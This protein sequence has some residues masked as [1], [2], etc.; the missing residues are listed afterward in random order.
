MIFNKRKRR[1]II[2]HIGLPKSGSTVLQQAL[3][4]QRE[5][6]LRQHVLYP[7]NVHRHDDPKHNFALD[8][9]RKGNNLNL[10]EEKGFAASKRIVISNEALSNEFYMQGI[11]HNRRLA[12]SLWQ[13]GELEICVVLR[14]PDSWLKSYY[15]QA[16]IN[17]PV[18]NKPHYQ[19]ALS[20]EAF[21][22]LEQVEKMLDQASLLLD[23]GAHYQAPVRAFRYEDTDFSAIANYCAGYSLK[24]IDTQ[25]RRNE[26]LPDV[27]VELMRQ[28]NGSITG[29]AEKHAWSYLLQRSI[30]SEHNVLN[31]LA[32]RAMPEDIG[33]LDIS[34]LDSIRP[35]MTQ[36]LAVDGNMLY[37]LSEKLRS[38]FI[39]YRKSEFIETSRW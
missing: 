29:L 15:K 18:K 4:Q 34:K 16:V 36:S 28:L 21:S 20:L 13:L 11:E 35:D 38:S 25:E 27:A 30:A 37:D 24:N 1:K 12:D 3:F 32:S 23:I 8:V 22:R 26:S 14:Q 17:Q 7:A 33:A 9:V 19:T 31:T 39:E 10:A 2:L 6:M 5:A